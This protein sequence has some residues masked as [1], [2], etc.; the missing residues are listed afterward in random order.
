MIDEMLG[1]KLRNRKKWSWYSE[2]IDEEFG[3]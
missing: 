3:S 1:A 2:R